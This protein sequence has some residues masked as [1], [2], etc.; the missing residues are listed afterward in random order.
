M[1]AISQFPIAFLIFILVPGLFGA[2]VGVVVTAIASAAMTPT[3]LSFTVNLLLGAVAYVVGSLIAVGPVQLSPDAFDPVSP[4]AI[5]S[6]VLAC[7][8]HEFVRWYGRPA[9]DG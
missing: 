8:A 7:G 5:W 9:S 1:K 4:E 6:A 3:R 2:A